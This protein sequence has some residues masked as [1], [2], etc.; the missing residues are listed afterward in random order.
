MAD[1]TKLT[2]ARIEG[3]CIYKDMTQEQWKE[4]IQHKLKEI[5]WNK[6]LVNNNTL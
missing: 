6:A 5:M 2:D 1:T 4:H 3:T